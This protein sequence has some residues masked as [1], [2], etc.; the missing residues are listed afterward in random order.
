[1]DFVVPTSFI[2]NTQLL[3]FFILTST[4]A[5]FWIF[6]RWVSYLGY[7]LSCAFAYWYQYAT[8]IGCVYLLLVIF[9]LL[10]YQ[11]RPSFLK[12]GLGILLGVLVFSLY[13]HVLPGFHNFK[14]INHIKLSFDSKFYSAYVNV[15]K[16]MVGALL[17]LFYPSFNKSLKE[18][19]ASLRVLPVPL[20][21]VCI[22]LLGTAFAMHYIRID[23][24]V[25]SILRVWIPTNLLLVCAMEE[26]FYRG[27]IQKELTKAFSSYKKANWFA[28]GI[29]S[30]IFGA[31][32]YTGGF[33][34]IVLSTLAGGAYG[35]VFMR[36][37]RIESSIMVHF[38]VNLI[39]I[40]AFSYPSLR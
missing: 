39:H 40:L 14:I 34:Y 35:Y 22:L 10:A 17:L 38:L 6:P 31:S 8:G 25:P 3:F 12:G 20:L 11:K 13:I 7:A 29:A 32:H 15:D 5:S 2:G 1:M 37:D 4:I 33:P 21:F 36:S 28:L 26:I 24:K 27:F 23:F 30:I 19:I 16:V 18:W 9:G